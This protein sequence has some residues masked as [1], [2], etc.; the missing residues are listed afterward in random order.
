MKSSKGKFDKT[1]FIAMAAAIDQ[2]RQAAR[3]IAHRAG[4]SEE[5]LAIVAHSYPGAQIVEV[6]EHSILLW[7][8]SNKFAPY[9][10]ADRW[11]LQ[12]DHP[13]LARARAATKGPVT[14]GAPHTIVQHDHDAK[15]ARIRHKTRVARS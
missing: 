12:T 7:D 8:N 1:K 10:V 15:V 6:E 5:E 11:T 14:E 2:I 9:I 13:R 3:G 4:W